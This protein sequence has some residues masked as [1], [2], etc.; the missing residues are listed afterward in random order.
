M[1]ARE[2]DGQ[3]GSPVGRGRGKESAGERQDLESFVEGDDAGGLA[4]S[5][6]GDDT[7]CAEN[8][9][10]T[11]TAVSEGGNGVGNVGGSSDFED[12]AL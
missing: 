1:A 5:D 10:S 8:G 7:G 9:D 12:V 2:I 3:A 11:V 6:I 4:K